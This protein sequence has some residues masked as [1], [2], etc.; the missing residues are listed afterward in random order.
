MESKPTKLLWASDMPKERQAK[1]F[2][3][4]STILENESFTTKNIPDAPD[5][6]C[7]VCYNQLA[8]GVYTDCQH[9]VV[10][11]ECAEAHFRAAMQAN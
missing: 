3:V 11:L 6:P 5:L 2:R 1:S 10:C 4:P 8:A 9:R 7:I